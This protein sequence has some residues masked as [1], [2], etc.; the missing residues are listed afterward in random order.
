MKHKLNNKNKNPRSWGAGSK[1][2]KK[3]TDKIPI[4]LRKGFLNWGTDLKHKHKKTKLEYR[5]Q[6]LSMG[7]PKEAYIY[8]YYEDPMSIPKEIL[9]RV[10]TR[11]MIWNNVENKF[12]TSAR[13][14]D[15]WKTE[16]KARFILKEYATI[17][18]VDG[19][20]TGKTYDPDTD[21]ELMMVRVI[22]TK[23]TGKVNSYGKS[24]DEILKKP[25]YK[26]DPMRGYVKRGKERA[27]QKSKRV[28]KKLDKEIEELKKNTK[29]LTHFVCGECK[30][31]YILTPWVLAHWNDRV[32][33][34]CKKCDTL[35]IIQYGTVIEFYQN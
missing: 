6:R 17:E 29:Q 12:F 9:E 10:T 26:D 24:F 31:E 23:M 14:T 33:F 11:Y 8:D 30:E 20:I 22:P 3:Y 18:K 5:N 35:N 4:P 16:K 1:K 32:K 19:K 7:K 25:K 28:I 2:G 21:L 13:A 15:W 34:V 27:L